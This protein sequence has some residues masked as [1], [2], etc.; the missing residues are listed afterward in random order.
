MN[1]CRWFVLLCISCYSLTSAVV[2]AQAGGKLPELSLYQTMLA[3]NQKTGWVQF[4][5]F[6][7]RQLIYFT[8]LQTLHCR[9]AE[10]RYSIN[11]ADLDKTFDLVKCNPHTPFSLPPKAKLKDIA[12]SLPLGT[13]SFVAVQVV[14]EDETES[15]IAIYEPCNDVGDQTCAIVAEE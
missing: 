9:L 2:S 4:R 13:A 6:N 10:I 1:F 11:S 7:G 14:W 8:P 5:N 12:I 15:D 3:A